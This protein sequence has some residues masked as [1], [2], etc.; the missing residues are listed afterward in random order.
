MPPF[1]AIS[2]RELIASLAF[3]AEFGQPCVL[4]Q[5]SAIENHFGVQ[6]PPDICELLL[7]FDGV[8]ADYGSGV[9]WSTAEIL[10][11]NQEFRTNQS[12]RELYMPFDHLLFFADD[13]GGDQFAFAIDADGQ[14][15]RYDVFRW[16]HET[17]A[18]TWFAGHLEQ[19][20]TTRLNKSS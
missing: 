8:R 11:H 7:E 4:G 9:V 19:Y 10:K 15:R 17:D 3:D 1:H 13:G 20:L 6:L 2:W 16:E 5:V 14:L 18:R 12:F